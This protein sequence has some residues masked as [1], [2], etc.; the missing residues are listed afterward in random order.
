MSTVV[1]FTRERLRQFSR[2]AVSPVSPHDAAALRH[3]SLFRAKGSPRQRC[4][5]DDQSFSTLLTV[6]R[7][8]GGVI[9][10]LCNP[11]TLTSPDH[12]AQEFATS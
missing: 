9:G 3:N 11:P 4:D 12:T 8:M 2:S 1:T 10:R 5:I 7:S 6:A